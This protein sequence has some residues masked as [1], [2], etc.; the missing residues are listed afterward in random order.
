CNECGHINYALTLADRVWTCPGCG[1]MLDR[2]GNA[3]RNIR[4]E[5][6][7]LVGAA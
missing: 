1:T 3:A 2:D 5:G 4:D 7:W 6:R